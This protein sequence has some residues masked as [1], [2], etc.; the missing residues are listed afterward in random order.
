MKSINI[1]LG[2]LK[3]QFRPILPVR[4]LAY[5]EGANLPALQRN[6]SNLQ[7][8]I[9]L[10]AKASSMYNI[11]DGVKYKSRFPHVLI[12]MPGARI[13]TSPPLK[14][15]YLYFTYSRLLCEELDKLGMLNREPVWD[16]KI[17]SV[18]TNSIHQL[19][20]LLEH[21][22]EFG[23]TD[24]IDMLALGLYQELILAG[25]SQKN[26][27]SPLENKM[28]KLSSYFQF[29]FKEDIN[30]EQIAHKFGFSRRSMFRHWKLHYN[31]TPAQYVFQ[32]KMKEAEH[33]LLETANSI[34]EITQ[35]LNYQGDAYFCAAFKKHSGL[36]PLQ[37]RK[38]YTAENK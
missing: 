20:D 15:E 18:I 38:K 19:G 10:N 13:Q 4:S 25:S 11:I 9:R 16:F 27:V 6:Y 22:N 3:R 23:I 26:S 36:T 31:T 17:N 24:R 34:G 21:S 37:Y 32:L 29:H 14:A 2:K 8:C 33:L 1:N 30:Y 35:E 28:Q 7:V 5:N 12:K